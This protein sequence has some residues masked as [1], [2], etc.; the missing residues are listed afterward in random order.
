MLVIATLAAQGPDRLPEGLAVSSHSLKRLSS[1]ARVVVLPSVP[2]ESSGTRRTCLSKEQTKLLLGWLFR[3]QITPRRRGDGRRRLL[4]PNGE[5]TRTGREA[6]H[7]CKRESNHLQTNF[8]KEH[9]PANGSQ[10]RL[11]KKSLL[12]P[13]RLLDFTVSVQL[14]F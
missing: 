11:K 10:Q 13:A 1:S 7:G 6:T 8:W 14:L 9:K 2:T 4:E 12:L 5:R 3:R